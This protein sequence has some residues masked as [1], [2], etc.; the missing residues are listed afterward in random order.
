MIRHYKC[1]LHRTILRKFVRGIKLSGNRIK[2][3]SGSK[4]IGL[5]LD[6][7]EWIERV[8]QG[9]KQS[10]IYS[11]LAFFFFPPMLVF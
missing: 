3:V 9:W 4:V 1:A 11:V 8:S 6:P 7:T 2:G 10:Q 5:V